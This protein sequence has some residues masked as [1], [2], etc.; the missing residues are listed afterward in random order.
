MP[1]NVLL[2][3]VYSTYMGLNTQEKDNP[4]EMHRTVFLLYKQSNKKV[5]ITLGWNRP[6]S[7][8]KNH[9]RGRFV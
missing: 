4:K 2:K 8:S 9:L 5:R 1:S 3:S 7:L 6:I